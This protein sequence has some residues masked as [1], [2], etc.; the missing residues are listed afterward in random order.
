M[1][2]RN[3]NGAARAPAI[4]APMI[5][6]SL[7]EDEAITLAHGVAS[8]AYDFMAARR[9]SDTDTLPQGRFWF[10]GGTVLEPAEASQKIK[11]LALFVLAHPGAPAEA[12]YLHMTGALLGRVVPAW[13]KAPLPL[14][15]AFGVFVAVLPGLVGEVRREAELRRNAEPLV[16]EPLPNSGRLERTVTRESMGAKIKMTHGDR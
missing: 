9:V 7:T 16:P 3:G 14:R 1:S 5:D 6:T 12:A 8:A 2:K 11:A 4:D 10:S 13:R 15:Q